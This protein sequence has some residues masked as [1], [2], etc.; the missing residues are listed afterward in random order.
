MLT[1]DAPF[2]ETCTVR[3]S[4]TNTPMQAL[5]LMNDPTYVEA[6]KFLAHRMLIEG[7][8][9]MESRLTYG[10][11]LVTARPPSSQELSYLRA[12]TLRTIADFEANPDEASALLKEGEAPFDESTSPIELAAYSIV[13]S[14]ILNL[15]ET[16]TRE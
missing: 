15:D 16:I 4:R 11:R 10:L 9:T 13:A 2:R 6:S 12:A 7:G 14:I 8:P 5:N 3:R 1:F